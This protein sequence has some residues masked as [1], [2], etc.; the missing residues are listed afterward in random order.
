MAFVMLLLVLLAGAVPARAAMD[1]LFAV[2]A[3]A[4]DE[5]AADATQ[6][7]MQAIMKAQRQ[8][9]LTLVQRL[10]GEKAAKRLANLPDRDIG[11]MLSSLSIADEQ[12]G[13]TRYIAR[14]TIR[15]SPRKITQLLRRKGIAF[16]T[17]QSPLVLVVPVWEDA[18]GPKLWEDNPWLKAWRAL[19]SEH[20]L[21][22]VT[23]PVG[24]EVDRQAISAVQAAQADETALQ[25]LQMRYGAEYVLVAIARPVDENAIQAAMVGRSPGGKVLF[26]KTYVAEEGGLDAAARQGAARFI[27]VMTLKW[28]QKVL[29][30]L[31]RERAQRAAAARAAQQQRLTV[32]V[33]F[34]S[35]REWQ[36]LRARISTVPGINGVDVEALSG[37]HAVVRLGTALSTPALK[38]A[39]G[40]A[41]LLL[42]NS[43]GRW[44]LQSY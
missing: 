10:A 15:F 32:I 39:L 5:T 27:E 40:N 16:I 14:I 33:P 9:F 19:A 41:G 38:Q 43:G 24:D 25:V 37:T 21:V 42:R 34:H 29:K 36:Q 35:L 17:R 22:P 8:A 23:V 12:T 26:D 20:A 1:K 31:A 13:P 18:D 6:A 11:R 4:V 28:R 7:K 3:I 44:Y 2:D 30:Q